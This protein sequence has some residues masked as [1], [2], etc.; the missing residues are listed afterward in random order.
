MTKKIVYV[1]MDGV[2]VKCPTEQHE[3]A[4]RARL[5]RK[6]RKDDDPSTDDV[7]WS[8][9]PD[10]FE[11]LEP[12]EN[13]IELCED[14]EVFICTTVPWNNL[15]AWA[16]KKKWVDKHLPAAHK[17]LIYTHRKDLLI[18]DYLIDD[19]INNGAGEFKGELIPFGQPGYEN[20][21]CVI[22]YLGS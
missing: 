5:N 1:D 4:K 8:D 6:G 18:G 10:I 11:D 2:L 17:R 14:Y 7:H 19:R 16:D 22:S 13:A 9:L 3:A 12:M 21:S 15:S 20:W